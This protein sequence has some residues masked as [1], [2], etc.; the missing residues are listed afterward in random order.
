MYNFE[1]KCDHDWLGQKLVKI[2]FFLYQG[3]VRQIVILRSL[4]VNEKKISFFICGPISALP[5]KGVFI[6]T[7]TFSH[8][9]LQSSSFHLLSS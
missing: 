9:P 5:L 4:L 7:G 2:T 3:Y 6:V 1:L 8:P